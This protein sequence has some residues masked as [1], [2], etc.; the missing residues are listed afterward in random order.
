M[1]N[2]LVRYATGEVRPRVGEIKVARQ[3]KAVHNEVRLAA[4]KSDGAL[5]LAAH[6]M[7]GIIGLDERRRALAQD[8][9]VTNE[10]LVRIEMAAVGH[11][12]SIQLNL[13]NG[14]RL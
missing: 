12:N 5:A 13:Y 7:E 6:V 8:D 14:W 11:I 1:N 10:M 3:A 2:E 4:L 9:P